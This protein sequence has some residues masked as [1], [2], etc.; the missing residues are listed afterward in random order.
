[1]LYPENF[2]PLREAR[3]RTTQYRHTYNRIRPNGPLGS[4]SPA[5]AAIPPAEALPILVRLT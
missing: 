1:M 5:P 3:V 4:R 2:Y